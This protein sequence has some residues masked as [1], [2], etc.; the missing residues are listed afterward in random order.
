[1]QAPKIV[2]W[3]LKDLLKEI[4]E[5]A[6]F[7]TPEWTISEEDKD[8]GAALIKIFARLL[9]GTAQRLNPVLQKN[10]IAFLNMLGTSLLPAQ[11]ARAPVTFALSAG[12]RDPVLL[13]AGTQVAANPADGGEPV[14]FETEK[15]M[16]ATPAELKAL[17]STVPPVERICDHSAQ[18]ANNEAIQLFA[19][20]QGQQQEHSIYLAHENLLN[21]EG[22]AVISVS[23]FTKPG[24]AVN[25]VHEEVSWEWWNGENWVPSTVKAYQEEGNKFT[26]VTTLARSTTIG[27]PVEGVELPVTSNVASDARFKQQGL[28]LIGNVIGVYDGKV[29]NNFLLDGVA[30]GEIPNYE[31]VFHF[32]KGEEVRA[33]DYPLL[34]ETVVQQANGMEWLEITLRK[35]FDGPFTKTAVNGVE[36]FWIRCRALQASNLRTSPLKN[37]AIDTINMK[38]MS[39]DEALIPD[40]L[41]NNDLPLTWSDFYPFGRQP[42]TFDAF[43]IACRDAFSKKSGYITMNFTDSIEVED[44]PVQKIQ[45]IGSHFAGQLERYGIGTLSQLLQLIPQELTRLLT[46]QIHNKLVHIT[47]HRAENI[48]EAARKKYYDKT[49]SPA[50]KLPARTGLEQKPVLSWEYWNGAA[51]DILSS[52]G[53]V[54]GQDLDPSF[55]FK[56]PEDIAPVKVNGLENYWIR[57][58]IADGDYGSV[59]YDLADNGTRLKPDRSAVRAPKLNQLTLGYRSSW[60]NPD[61]CVTYNNLN[62][63]DYTAGARSSPDLL[64]PFQPL[65]HERSALYL[66][67]EP[68]PLKGMISIFFSLEEESYTNS[69]RPRLVWE[70]FREGHRAGS[71]GG[72]E[73][74]DNTSSLTQT[75]AVEF[76]GPPDFTRTLCFGRQ[77]YWIRAVDLEGGFFDANGKPVAVA[78]KIKGIYMNTTWAAQVETVMEEQHGLSLGETASAFRLSKY[79]VVSE[80]IWVNEFS[81]LSESEQATLAAGGRYEIKEVKDKDGKLTEFWTRWE[82]VDDLMESGALDR[83]YRI[84]RAFG[85][86]SLGDGINGKVPPGGADRIKVNYRTGGGSKGNMGQAEISELRTSIAFV[87][88]VF[89]PAAAGGGSDTEAVEEALVRGK[90]VLK[91]RDRAVTAE[92]FE[93]L[94][95]QSSRGVAR[96]KCLPNYKGQ[97]AGLNAPGSV[98]VVIVPASA[99]SQPMPSIQLKSLVKKYL[100]QRCANVVTAPDELVV[101]EPDYVEISVQATLATQEFATATLAEMEAVRKLKAFL[102]PLTGGYNGAGWDF[103]RF[104]HLSDLYALLEVIPGVDHVEELSMHMINTVTGESVTVTPGTPLAANNSPAALVFSGKHS[105]TVK[106][107]EKGIESPKSSMAEGGQKGCCQYRT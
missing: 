20:S 6:P 13:P 107:M 60:H 39:I 54:I 70:Y 85:Q 32:N 69:R 75:G 57:V 58:R 80:E 12:A 95:K 76:I 62:Y 2:P 94:A 105:I 89:N 31:D 65:D 90:Q 72:L 38:V 14:L 3:E 47:E 44:I 41:F 98:T 63:H 10:F 33:I 81:V 8:A 17:F 4:R 7:Y 84:D 21:L 19:Q 59:E 49:D 86:V 1:M 37:L 64:E 93:W 88:S 15:N 9:E 68:P 16:L 82:P 104:P 46:V 96:A 55:Y 29:E 42:R 92:D 53:Y 83:H 40:A 73:V 25:Y 36:N 52:P 103:G 22:K 50:A 78:P 102:H 35:S 27:Y 26:A 71:W 77:L 48:L 79:P 56:C 43:Y 87:D 24:T 30:F 100:N 11:P 67:F 5:M 61:R 91:H 99:G 28:L 23:F 45:G 34:V 66:G 18:L 101:K 51:W 97:G 106:G 74:L